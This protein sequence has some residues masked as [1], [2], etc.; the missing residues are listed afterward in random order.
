ML[1]PRFVTLQYG[2]A[3]YALLSGNVPMAVWTGADNGSQM[4]VYLFLEETEAVR[5]VQLRTPEFLPFNLQ[6]G[7]FLEPSETVGIALPLGY[8]YGASPNSCGDSPDEELWHVG[9]GA[10]LI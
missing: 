9:V 6:A 1:R 7:V 10:H 5:N 2:Q 8:G 3:S 4:G